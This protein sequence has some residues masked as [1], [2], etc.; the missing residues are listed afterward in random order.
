MKRLMIKLLFAAA[1]CAM[2]AVPAFAADTGSLLLIDVEAPVTVF[3]VADASGVPNGDFAGTVEGLSL[4]D[5]K[6]EVAQKLYK[7]VQDKELSGQT[8][9]PNADKELLV[10]SLDKGW[11]L[12][13]STGEKAE[14]A[15]FLVCIPMTIGE[16]TVYDIQA[17]PKVDSP[18]DP[19]P[20]EPIVPDP[21]IPQTGAVQWPKYL[22]LILGA[23]F[24]GAGVFEVFR[25]REKRHE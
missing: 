13:C 16:K 14:F 21:D 17:E 19:G 25:G 9:T 20:S 15:P 3:K 12:V 11:Y 6:P 7:H 2:L 4:E 8:G 10:G 18:L 5:M 23:L 1:L 22:L 24:I